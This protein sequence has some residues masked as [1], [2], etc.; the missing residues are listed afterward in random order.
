MNGTNKKTT[1]LTTENQKSY[2][3]K[4][5]ILQQK[6]TNITTKNY[7]SYNNKTTNRTTTTTN[8]I[9]IKLSK[10]SLVPPSIAI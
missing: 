1:N 6:T 7:K 8:P 3:K 9:T 4:L 10:K 5:Q 2:N